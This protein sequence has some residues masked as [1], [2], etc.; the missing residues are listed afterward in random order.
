MSAT[1]INW[2]E[3]VLGASIGALIGTILGALVAVY[4]VDR[5]VKKKELRSNARVRMFAN[6]RAYEV[7]SAILA[8]L[9]PREFFV[10]FQFV[11]S[12][13]SVPARDAGFC[14]HDLEVD[15]TIVSL[16]CVSNMSDIH[17]TIELHEILL[18][19]LRELDLL[20]MGFGRIEDSN[21]LA[22][23]VGLSRSISSFVRYASVS[24][25]KGH[26]FHPTSP[27]E[28]ASYLALMIR[29]SRVRRILGCVVSS[30]FVQD[31]VVQGAL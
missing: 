27:S 14:V 12:F 18:G 20:I 30:R 22:E 16:S 4:W 5:Q 29:C 9:L 15:D 8:R 13:D 11:V 25:V 31:H 26:G 10:P 19:Y 17:V 21:E 28:K 2:I 7:A 6:A 24:L 3:L 1:A 23:T